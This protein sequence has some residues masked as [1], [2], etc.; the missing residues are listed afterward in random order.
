MGFPASAVEAVHTRVRS[1]GVEVLIIATGVVT[2][3]GIRGATA[4]SEAAAVDHAHD[5]VALEKAIGLYVEADVQTVVV[6]SEAMSTFFNWVYIW[7]HWP[8]IVATLLWLAL[9]HRTVYLRLRN[10]MM[11]SGGLGLCV[12]TTYPVAPPRLAGLGMVDT[13]SERSQAYRVLQ[14]PQFVN[15]YAAMPSLHVGWDLLVGLAILAAATATWLRVVGG[16]MPVF[17]ALATVATA[18]H[19]V[20]DAVAGVLFALAGLAAALWLERRR[21]RRAAEEP[22]PPVP[23]PPAQRPAWEP[24]RRR[25]TW[26]PDVIPAQLEHVDLPPGTADLPPGTAVAPPGTAVAPAGPTPGPAAGSR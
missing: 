11:I 18:N 6:P 12:Y 23:P 8:V 5:I 13:V 22:P 10:G 4:G 17:M 26:L 16:L 25:R 7:G 24:E 2:Y 21:E 15:Q 19:Y 1:V 3:F 14:P 20:L 9:Q